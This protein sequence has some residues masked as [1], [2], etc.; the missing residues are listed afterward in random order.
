[1]KYRI[2][3]RAAFYSMVLLTAFTSLNAQ[4]NDILAS[5]S[6]DMNHYSEV[7]TVTKQNESYQ[8]YI[9]SVFQGEE[10]EKLGVANLKEAL[11]LVPGVDMATDNLNTKTP[12]FRGSNSLAFG[13]S[14]LFID[15]TL[16][17]NLFFDAYSEYLGLPIEM[18][19]RVEVVRGPG[20]K[21]DGVNAYAGSIHVITYAEDFNEFESRDKIVLKAGSYH[22]KMGGFIKTY[23]ADDFKIFVDFFYQEDDKQLH[24]GP[25][26]YSQGSMSIPGLF[27]N[28]GLSKNG[29]APL[30]LKDYSL[31]L[32][33]R[34]K[35]F[36]LKGRILE[37]TQG[38][39]YG[40]NLSLPEDGGR[41][42]L[43]SYYLEA[44][45]NRK[46][47]DYTIDIKGGVK[48]DAFDSKDKLA[49]DGLTFMDMV[50]YDTDHT[51]NSVTFPDGVYGE[52]YALQRTLYQS[53]YLKYDGINNHVVTT[54]YRFV[55]EET[56]EMSSKLSNW[57]TGDVALV[58]YTEIYPFFDKNAKRDTLIFSLQD[59][60]R[61]SDDLNFIYGFNYEQTSNKDAGF[62]PRVSVVYQANL[63]NI[64]KA[65][66]SRSHR[67]PS[68]QEMYT[69]NNHSRVGNDNLEPE[70]VDAFELAYIR[71]FLSDTYV[72]TNLFYL[73]NK[74]QIYHSAID[75]E[76]KN[77]VDTDIY[78]FEVEYK[79]HI[80]SV[81]RLYLNYAYVTGSSE[82]KDVKESESLSNIAHHLVK[83]YYIYNLDND[84]SLSSVVKYV[85]SK[86]RASG[87]TRKKVPAYTTVD[88]TLNYKN[89]KYDYTLM[90]SIK[91]IFDAGVTYPSLPNTY[92]E[93]YVQEGR[94]FLISV[95]KEF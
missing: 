19:K 95:R 50:Q 18:I 42:K 91:N 77:V 87:D 29:D 40:I 25:D 43:P 38:N 6:N 28:T 45:Y 5:I 81:D 85:S 93:D 69:M 24:A 74:D 68:W 51:V 80:S 82:I 15:G 60:Y 73:F 94:N 78:G 39:A 26:G 55:K 72:Q 75:P 32:N 13:Q 52:H 36:S 57:A 8:P 53:S 79:G 49:P 23:K 7:A 58:D 9:I 62:E 1:M 44:G 20:S 30:W 3:T 14:K 84:L 27:D 64:Y 83:G 63:E 48:Y 10:L 37:H 46:I 92:I 54:G 35:D 70:K 12:I 61:F 59:E 21:T 31:N 16:V 66:Y 22:Y 33:L 47:N 11:E 34:Y 4:T 89:P 17:N 2:R 41:V 67:N 65:M 71:K 56:I 88:T 90:L 86:E 76:Y